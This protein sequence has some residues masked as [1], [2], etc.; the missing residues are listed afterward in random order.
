VSTRAESR[1]VYAAGLVQG[2]VLVTFPAASTIFTAPGGYGLSSTRYGVMF[3]PQACLAVVTALAEGGL[4]RRFGAKQ[5]Y[6]AGL[7]A[8]LA[9][10]LLLIASRF[11]EGDQAVAYGLLLAATAC[12]GAG[13]GLTV[14]SVNTFAAALH[15]DAVDRS[16]LVLNSLLGL[17]TALAPVFIAV[18]VGLGF[19]VGLPVL[20]ALA[21]AAL[22]VVSVRLPL[23]AGS[24]GPGT[25]AGRARGRGVVPLGFWVFAVF[26]TGYGFCETMNGNWS[27]LDLTSLGVSSTLA[28]L[29]LTVFW[30]MVTAGRVLFAVVARWFPSRLAYHLLPFVL[31]GAFALI[32]VLPRDA[33]L[34]GIGAF[35]LA[36]FGCS[37]LLPLTIS[38]GQEKLTRMSAAVA[39]LVIAFYQPGYGIAAFGVGPLRRAGLSLPGLYAA[40][41]VVAL[42]LGALSFVVAYR[43]PSPAS[44]HPRPPLPAAAGQPQLGFDDTSPVR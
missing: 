15:P 13:F 21:V 34:A 8:D 44:V 19:W 20:A 43:R 23:R 7:V 3:L 40:S 35:A 12:A 16:V 14:P 28:S 41:G 6:L 30:G 25:G 26:A 37:A 24:P 22:M 2:V 4:A 27:Q 32:A 39:G 38:F 33:G 1:A 10:M 42:A 29:T 18:F 36:G 5:V 9:A 31:A 17:G 11:A